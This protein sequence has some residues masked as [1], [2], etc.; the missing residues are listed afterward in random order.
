MG[1]GRAS[2]QNHSGGSFSSARVGPT[3]ASQ[4]K[5]E[6]MRARN[7][8]VSL[9]QQGGELRIWCATFTL[10]GSLPIKDGKTDEGALR[11]KQREIEK[12]L[13]SLEFPDA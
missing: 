6:K 2:N 12:L 3:Q 1:A 11:K 13:E 9:Y 4:S 7:V 10:K 5:E 8:S